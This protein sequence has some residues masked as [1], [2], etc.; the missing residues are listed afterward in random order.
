[1]DYDGLL[2]LAL[3]VKCAAGGNGVGHKATAAHTPAIRRPPTH[4]KAGNKQ[5]R[6]QRGRR[7]K[8]PSSHAVV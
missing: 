8:Q 3:S 1:M 7:R 2:A 6:Q 4:R 5:R